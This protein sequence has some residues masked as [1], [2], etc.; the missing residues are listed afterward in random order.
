M[1]P[2]ESK[3]LVKGEYGKT[4]APIP[5]EIKKKILGDEGQI[6]CRPADLLPPSLKAYVRR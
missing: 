5:D 6:T 1:V 2:K 4:P 3:A